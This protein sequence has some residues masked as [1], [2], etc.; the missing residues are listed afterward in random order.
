MST[1][2]INP[3][4][5]FEAVAYARNLNKTD[6][7]GDSAFRVNF[8]KIKPGSNG[9]RYIDFEVLKKRPTGKWEYI[10]LNLKFMHLNTRARIL[11]PDDPKR[12]I[13]GV[14]LQFAHNASY[15]VNT[16]KKDKDGKD[17]MVTEEYSAAKILIAKAYQ[18]IMLAALKDE[19]IF[20]DNSKICLPVQFERIIDEKTKKKA[21]LDEPIVRMDIKFTDGDSETEDN[22]PENKAPK[23]GP[24]KVKKDEQKLTPSSKPRCDIYDVNKKI[25]KT[26][27]KY[28][29]GEWNFEPL[30]YEKDGKV[31]D[32][33][34]G[35]I[36]M[37]IQP[38]SSVSGVDCMSSISLSNMGISLASKATLLVVKPSKGFKP[39]PTQVFSANDI[40][41]FDTAVTQ[42]F[43][44]ST[45]ETEVG[46]V[47]NKDEFDIM[48][49]NVN[50]DEFVENDPDIDPV[51]EKPV[52]DLE[53]EYS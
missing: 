10:P 25:L 3:S 2:T 7:F 43:D 33:T 32:L 51:E 53:E 6:K 23:K 28:K 30:R 36:G 13:P 45:V 42:D 37:V 31:E 20:N 22:D 26:D 17:I 50:P 29:E 8:N 21:K 18:R 15:T 39:L 49:G 19:K 27:P 47:K 11:L 5:V 1:E 14:Q 16:K 38:G 24:I 48:T 4:Q 46:E 44:E 40:E 9:V 52:D 12:K 34:Y 41:S 35:N